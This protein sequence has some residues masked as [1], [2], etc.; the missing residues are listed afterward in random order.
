MKLSTLTVVSL[1]SLSCGCAFKVESRRPQSAG[2]MNQ[3]MTSNDTPAPRPD[4]PRAPLAGEEAQQRE[5]PAGSIAPAAPVLPP[6]PTLKLVSA[7]PQPASYAFIVGIER[8]RDIPAATGAGADADGYAQLARQTLGLRDDHVRLAVGDHATRTDILEG[9]EW[10]KSSVPPGGRAYFF[11]SGH[12]APSPDSSTYLLPY[13][14]NPKDVRRSAIAMGDVM[15][16]L[17]ETQARE[18]LAVVDACFSGAGGR[19]VLPPGARPLMLVKDAQPTAK[20]ALF[21]ASQGDEISGAAADGRTGAFTKYV[22]QGL[23]QGRADANGDGQI[24]L[25][26]LDGWVAPRVAREAQRDKREQHPKLIVGSGL[27]DASNL[28]LEYGLAAE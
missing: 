12:G 15:A 5:K 3:G 13:D 21:T 8:Y 20:V 11:F 26:E 24:S 7:T 27:G 4:S 6:A 14:G 25:A 22:L 10:L 18:V 2:G 23:G 17:G 9:L 19:S 28:V 16:A 1:V